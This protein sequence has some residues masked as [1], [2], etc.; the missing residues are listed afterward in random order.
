MTRDYHVDLHKLYL[1]SV[2][3]KWNN[4]H[5]Q[6]LPSEMINN[7]PMHQKK[8]IFSSAL[9]KNQKANYISFVL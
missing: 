6:S 5:K 8:F 2:K 1:Q 9:K 4:R 7:W 3:Q